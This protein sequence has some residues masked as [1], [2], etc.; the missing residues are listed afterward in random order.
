[1]YFSL[2][3]SRDRGQNAARRWRPEVL[4]LLAGLLVTSPAFSYAISDGIE[5]S[6][7]LPAN[8]SAIRLA[9]AQPS[10]DEG[11]RTAHYPY[12]RRSGTKQE[13]NEGR[14]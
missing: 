12:S 4:A 1:M 5:Q 6:V 2:A 8:I 9:Q 13:Q 3:G 7:I 14:F 10:P 11:H